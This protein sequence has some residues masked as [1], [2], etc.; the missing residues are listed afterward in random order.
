MSTLATNVEYQHSGKAVIF[1]HIHSGH[2]QSEINKKGCAACQ[3]NEFNKSNI[4]GFVTFQ[5]W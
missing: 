3:R 4:V 2:G 1:S 5:K